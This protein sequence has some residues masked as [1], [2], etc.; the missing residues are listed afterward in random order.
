[1]SVPTDSSSNRWWE[2]YLVRY[3]M[4]SIAGTAIVMWL[5]AIAAEPLRGL[6]LLP[7]RVADLNTASLTL[8]FLY[9]NLFCYIASYPVLS[10]HAT[11]VLNQPLRGY[12]FTRLLDG[13]GATLVLGLAVLLLPRCVPLESRGHLAILLAALFSAV[14][15][16][17]LALS[18]FPRVTVDGLQG[19]VS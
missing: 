8:L 18:V 1:M 6:L 9:G 13:Y 11:R 10:F 3:L 17:R 5:G 12:G 14:Q 15:I 7:S 19:A 4:P 2:S 16:A